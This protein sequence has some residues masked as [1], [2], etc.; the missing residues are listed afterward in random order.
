[1]KYP[2]V[3]FI[4]TGALLLSASASAQVRYVDEN[5]V[6]HWV[7]SFGQVPERYREQVLERDIADN[8][9]F[10]PTSRP[11]KPGELPPNQWQLIQRVF[12]DRGRRLARRV[13]H[14]DLSATACLG[15]METL[16]ANDPNAEKGKVVRTKSGHGIAVIGRGYR[17]ALVRVWQCI[18]Q[19]E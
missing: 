18:E 10:E 15:M 2:E 12:E 7:S 1:M 3:A 4:L 17:D 19:Q 16:A 5:G 13:L 14:G 6:A 9:F 8:P 11:R